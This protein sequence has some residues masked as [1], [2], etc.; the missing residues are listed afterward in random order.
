MRW[1]TFFIL[2]YVAVTAQTTLLG[3]VAGSPIGGAT[4]HML[5]I[6]ALFYA[7]HARRVEA[8]WAV[9]LLGLTADLAATHR[10]GVYAVCFTL[11][12]LGIVRI[13]AH[14]FREHPLSV[15]SLAAVGTFLVETVAGTVTLL[16]GDLST[17]PWGRLLG[18]ALL[19][20][21]FTA[22]AAVPLHWLLRRGRRL[23]G[24]R[25]QATT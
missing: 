7:L 3:A 12:G 25:A 21:A 2:A 1:L 5:F 19:T 20:A 22:I 23:L 13:R 16:V 6:L 10:F 15:L 9:L 18:A 8:L 11:A 24:T 14:L 17:R 4:V